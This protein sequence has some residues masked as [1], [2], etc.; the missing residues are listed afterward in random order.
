MVPLS[1][2]SIKRHLLESERDLRED[3]AMMQADLQHVQDDKY[4]KRWLRQQQGRTSRPSEFDYD[5]IP[6]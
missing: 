3:I 1:A 5:D 4:L 6:F 2:A